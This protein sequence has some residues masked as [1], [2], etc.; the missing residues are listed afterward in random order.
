MIKMEL[1]EGTCFFPEKEDLYRYIG[2]KV[3]REA[4]DYLLSQNKP[5]TPCVG[6]CDYTY[7]IEEGWRTL[8]DELREELA[9]L[10]QSPR[11]SRLRLEKL[12]RRMNRV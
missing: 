7:S 5:L 9:L 8:F 2:E 1:K 4:E 11:L 10:L 6:E 3:G 12:L